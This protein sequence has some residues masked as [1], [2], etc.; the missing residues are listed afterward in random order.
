[1]AA[2]GRYRTKKVPEKAPREA[3]RIN[4]LITCMF[5]R[6]NM[7]KAET[8]A[9]LNSWT[10]TIECIKCFN[11]DNIQ[12]LGRLKRGRTINVVCIKTK[13]CQREEKTGYS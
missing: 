10:V 2:A 3:I 12:L 9:R 1:M 13:C 11:V 4:I 8:P 5:P 6:E 7:G